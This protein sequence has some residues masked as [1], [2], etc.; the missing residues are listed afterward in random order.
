MTQK[1][2]ILKYIVLKFF[3]GGVIF[4]RKENANR[5][6]EINHKKNNYE[7]PIVKEAEKS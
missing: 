7:T 1:S 5:L 6:V 2:Q 4:E 3:S